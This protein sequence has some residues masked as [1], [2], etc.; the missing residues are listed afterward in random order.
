MNII[1]MG[2]PKAGKTS[3]LSVVFQ[4]MSPHETI[5]IPP[6]KQIETIRKCA[7]YNPD[8]NVNPHI[9]FQIKDFPSSKELS[10][11]DPSDVQAL[12]SCSSLIFVIDAHEQD[13]EMACNKFFEIIKVAYKINPSIMFE[14]FIHKVD[15]DLYM[16]DEQKFD[17]LNE[18]SM[19]MRGLLR[20]SGLG[21]EGFGEDANSVVRL[22]YNLTS[23]Y[24]LTIYQALS[25]VI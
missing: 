2:L 25:Q 19:S 4:K 16:Q 14:V 20:D 6:T 15:P 22:Q 10:V 11:D 5:F 21:G 1:F 23:I 8:T 3:I 9:Q 24:D 13:K 12:R 17:T 18:I 7:S